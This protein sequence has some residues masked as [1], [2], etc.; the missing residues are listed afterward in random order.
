MSYKSNVAYD[1]S[2][3]A[4]EEEPEVIE[5]QPKVK[6]VVKK[7]KAA[8]S[9]AVKPA[10]VVKW[11]FMSLFVMLS[12][13]SIMIGNIKIT[14]LNDEITS[15]QKKLDTARSV[16]VS[17]NSKLESRMSLANVE[18]YAVD[19]LGLV[20]VQPYQIKYV[21]LTDTDKV[22]VSEDDS[23]VTGFFKHIYD[24]VLEYFE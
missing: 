11:V 15:T 10:T 17:L 2:L 12:L 4:P 24:S 22:E 6:K 9:K 16:Q 5:E 3:F 14:Q 21:H 8:A 1:F 18:E 13:V 20:K 7:R 19:K 23:G